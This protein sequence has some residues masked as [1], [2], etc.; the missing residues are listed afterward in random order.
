ME[1]KRIVVAAVGSLGDLHPYLAIALGLKERGHEAIVATSACYRSKVEALGLCH[2]TIRPD[3]D[4]VTDPA[5]M[6]RFMD[7][8]LGTIRCL[9]EFIVPALADSYED[10]LAAAEGAD[11]LV[12]HFITYA[13]GLVA[14]K[15][16]IPWVSTLT[17]PSCVFSAYDPPLIPGYPQV[18]TL[19]R[20]LG[21]TF[22]R[23]THD[24]LER[25]SRPWGRP[26][27][28]LRKEVGLPPWRGNALVDRHSP[29]LILALFSKTLADK[30]VDWPPQTVVT[31]FP[32]LD[33][34][35]EAVM[36]TELERFL[37]AGS[38]PIVFTLGITAAL[39]GGRFFD[40]SVA[41]AKAL[42]RRAVLVG[43]RHDG[44]LNP[45]PA[46]TIASEYVP[47]AQLF[48]RAAAV[49]HAGGI[50]STG[51]AMR[52][53]RPMLVVPFAH[54]QPDNAERMHRLGIASTIPG[55][56][57]TA[58]RA[59][60]ALRPLLEDASYAR[61]AA[62]IGAKVR[63]EDGVRNT[64]DAIESFLRGRNPCTAMAGAGR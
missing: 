16:G 19:L 5:V 17:T 63:D 45:L 27:H 15:L 3:S 2:R 29:D 42:G 4:C 20:P 33:K 28:R 1:A 36:P 25:V 62:E 53:G 60:A 6:G 49:V 50:S 40:E 51:L 21:P 48:P 39:V 59:V 10:T 54:D 18:S 11:L 13:T 55:R 34:G 9:R 37:D 14:E 31:G 30:Q 23:V 58:A 26:W 57:Y 41:A 46:D 38:P 52:S 43:K 24:I 64:C 8:R 61:R 47:F 12:S 22:W 7:Q 44:D 35:K 32:I 56:R